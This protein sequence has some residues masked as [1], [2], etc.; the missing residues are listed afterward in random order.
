MSPTPHRTSFQNICSLC[1]LEFGTTDKAETPCN[2][3][4]QEPTNIPDKCSPLAL[5]IEEQFNVFLPSVF[6]QPMWLY[7]LYCR[8]KRFKSEQIGVAMPFAFKIFLFWISI[9]FLWSS[10]VSLVQYTEICYN[11]P[12]LSHCGFTT[13]CHLLFESFDTKLCFQTNVKN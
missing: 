9:R 12:F 3:R 13:Y 4:P 10:S 1:S 2:A 5:I 11:R 7:P 6:V 8:T